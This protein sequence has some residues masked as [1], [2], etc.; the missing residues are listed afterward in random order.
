MFWGEMQGISV[1][2]WPEGPSPPLAVRDDDA[3]A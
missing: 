2:Q 3:I 1:G